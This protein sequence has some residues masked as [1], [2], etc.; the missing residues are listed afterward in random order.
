MLTKVV[1][2]GIS[3]VESVVINEDKGKY[4]L[5]AE[6]TNLAA[7]MDIEGV[8][9]INTKS[10]HVLEIEQTLRIEATR[11]VIIDQIEYTMK[12]HGM[13]IDIR[14]MMP[15]SIS[16]L[17]LI[18]DQSILQSVRPYFFHWPSNDGFSS[19]YCFRTNFLNRFLI[20]CRVR[21]KSPFVGAIKW[22]RY[23]LSSALTAKRLIH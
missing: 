20:A 16:S 11:S 13:S 23:L 4:N 15:S 19:T 5:L 9:G 7:M 3:I 10:N 6:G 21:T 1:V 22:L 18:P 17:A 12:N 8:D 14:H 2:K